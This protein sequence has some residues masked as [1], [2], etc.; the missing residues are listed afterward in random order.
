MPCG[1]MAELLTTT[2]FS[3]GRWCH[4]RCVPS[5]HISGERR[6]T[7]KSSEHMMFERRMQNVAIAILVVQASERLNRA[8]SPLPE[9]SHPAIGMAGDVH[10]LH[11]TV[12]DL[13]IAR[14]SGIRHTMTSG[15]GRRGLKRRCQDR[16]G[17]A[18][19]QIRANAKL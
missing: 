6:G 16:T 1:L 2:R 4:P 5:E 7:S 12:L 14:P 13:A 10:E 15:R 18:R 11:S 17:R 19:Y 9:H 3:S 8:I